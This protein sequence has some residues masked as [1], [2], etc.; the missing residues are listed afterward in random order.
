MWTCAYVREL[1]P[2]LQTNPCSDA[3]AYLVQLAKVLSEGRP[4]F[5]TIG[6][7]RDVGG[8]GCLSVSGPLLC[9]FP[10]RDVLLSY[11]TPS[12]TCADA[13]LCPYSFSPS[14]AVAR[15]SSAVTI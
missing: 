9:A 6:T 12:S 8:R 5:K 3:K 14:D 4:L 7:V 1:L 2:S 15:T 10:I 11:R 13:F